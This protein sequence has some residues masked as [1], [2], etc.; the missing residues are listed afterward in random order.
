M[1]CLDLQGKKGDESYFSSLIRRAEDSYKNRIVL[2]IGGSLG[3]SYELRKK[4]R[5]L[6]TMSGLTYPHQLFRI[7]LMEA[8]D[9][10]L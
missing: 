8:L 10:Y 4:A 1:V 7:A 9:L 5:D 3:I 2:V 6:I